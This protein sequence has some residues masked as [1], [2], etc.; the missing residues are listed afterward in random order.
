MQI[1]SENFF[2]FS[3]VITFHFPDTWS[4]LNFKR[5]TKAANRRKEKSNC[6][7]W[8]L[9]LATIVPGSGMGRVDYLFKV[10]IIDKNNSF[11]KAIFLC[12]SMRIPIKATQGKNVLFLSST[13]K[14]CNVKIEFLFPFK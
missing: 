6:C 12:R 2:P 9:S 3:P 7:P 13:R 5:V 4:E 14:M 10:C 11:I 8:K 1:L